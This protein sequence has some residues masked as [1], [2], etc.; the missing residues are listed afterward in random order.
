MIESKIE[1]YLTDKIK[2]IGGLCWKFVSPGTRGVPDRLCILPNGRTIYVE[3]K[4][5][6]EVPE[7]L[8]SKRHEQLRDRGHI[9]CV[10]DSLK[11]V[12]DFINEQKR[13]DAI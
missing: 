7:P 11:G 6:G 9:V 2:S 1:K 8:Q 5:P 3:L 4:R 10:I 12:D 13:G